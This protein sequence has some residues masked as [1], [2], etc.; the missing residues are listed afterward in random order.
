MSQ[1]KNYD[2]KLSVHVCDLYSPP[3]G[4]YNIAKFKLSTPISR[5]KAPYYLFSGQN[6][7]VT[8]W[9]LDVQSSAFV[10]VRVRKNIFGNLNLY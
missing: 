3:S 6:G 10:R 9:G 7:L 2:K 5:I 1:I 8:G 4:E